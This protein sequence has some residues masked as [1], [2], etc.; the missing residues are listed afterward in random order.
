MGLLLLQCALLQAHVVRAPLAVCAPQSSSSQ[1][2]LPP[3]PPGN[4]EAQNKLCLHD[5]DFPSA[6]TG[7]DGFTFVDVGLEKAM[8]KEVGGGM[9]SRQIGRVGTLQARTLRQLQQRFSSG[10]NEEQRQLVESYGQLVYANVHRGRLDR[11]VARR[12][13]AACIGTCSRAQPRAFTL[14]L[15]LAVVAES[16]G[17]ASIAL[18]V[19]SGA[20][21]PSPPPQ[22]RAAPLLPACRDY[23]PGR[24]EAGSSHEAAVHRAVQPACRLPA[25]Q[26]C[27]S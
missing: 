22:P 11:S 18:P 17:R 12:P 2:N 13:V 25:G 5:T 16:L 10:E 8:F 3:P 14:P 1:P 6:V 4:Y 7:A 23:H 26:R 9:T 24:E 20:A 21:G 15:H 27:W 19:T